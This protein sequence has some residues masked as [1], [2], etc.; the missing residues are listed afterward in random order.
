VEISSDRITITASCGRRPWHPACSSHASIAQR[1]LSSTELV[2][3]YFL[4]RPGRL[5]PSTHC[6][7]QGGANKKAIDDL[8]SEWTGIIV[9]APR[10]KE[11]SARRWD[12]P[13]ARHCREGPHLNSLPAS[14][15]HRGSRR[16]LAP[17]HLP[18]E[19]NVVQ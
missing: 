16:S 19:H 11:R 2:R 12:A 18:W 3:T 15:P 4:R 9:V 5:S 13:A 7:V 6:S 1:G 14:K 8:A 17:L 10:A